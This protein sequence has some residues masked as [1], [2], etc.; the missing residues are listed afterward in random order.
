MNAFDT[1]FKIITRK[2]V[3]RKKRVVKR[4]KKTTTSIKDYTAK[5]RAA[6]LLVLELIEK[7][8]KIYNF[9]YGQI[10][11]RNQKTRWGSCSN[12]G[13]LNFNYRIVDLPPRLA[14]YIVIHELCHLKEMNH[15]TSF[16]NLVAVA[17]PDYKEARAE[18]KNSGIR[19]G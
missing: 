2:V 12:H 18:L 15:A 4:K 10:A 17:M 14:E 6:R 8:N 3:I 7:V 5:K 19:L 1:F 9:E 11:I 16:W 13:N